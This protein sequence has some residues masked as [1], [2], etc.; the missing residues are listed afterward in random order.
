MFLLTRV[1]QS[2][3]I[4]DADVSADIEAFSVGAGLGN[5]LCAD[6]RLENF[7]SEN[8]VSGFA[9]A[10]SGSADEDQASFVRVSVGHRVGSVCQ[11]KEE[12]IQNNFNNE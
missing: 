5:R 4:N 3:R 10:G 11:A 12:T 7:F 9:L 2:R 1:E 6:R 8:F